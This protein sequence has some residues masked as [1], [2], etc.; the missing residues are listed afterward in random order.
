MYHI[1]LSHILTQRRVNLCPSLSIYAPQFFWQ[2]YISSV[3]V[4]GCGGDGEEAEQDAF[5]ETMFA[6]IDIDGNGFI[7]A[8]ELETGDEW[9]AST[10]L[11]LL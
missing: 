9:I 8:E 1:I 6:E 11:T 10:V 4:S 7:D 3:A 5:L 2:I